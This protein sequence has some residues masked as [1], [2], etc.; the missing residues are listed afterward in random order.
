M[1]TLFEGRVRETSTLR[2]V[3]LLERDKS[4]PAFRELQS[5]EALKFMIEKD[6]CN[7][8]QLVRDKRKLNTRR[9]F[10]GELFQSVDVYLLNTIETPEESLDRIK[11]II[12]G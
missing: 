9:K 6:F 11:N 12:I 4:N 10:F 1:K 5:Q 2:S 7:P 8:H 3:V